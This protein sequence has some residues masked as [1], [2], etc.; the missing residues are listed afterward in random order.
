MVNREEMP[1]SLTKIL[2]G[3]SLFALLD[4]LVAKTIRTLVPPFFLS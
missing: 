3:A 2:T 1:A 4:G